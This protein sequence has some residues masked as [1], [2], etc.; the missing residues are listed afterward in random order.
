M[1]LYL[2]PRK[3]PFCRVRRMMDYDEGR[4]V[5]VC[6]GCRREVD[7]PASALS[8]PEKGKLVALA[9]RYQIRNG[10]NLHARRD[11]G[12]PGRGGGDAPGDVGK[13]ARE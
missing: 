4:D 13:V 3:C 8:D 9:V 11:A 5:I 12:V 6:Q 10:L 1:G 2:G 7:T